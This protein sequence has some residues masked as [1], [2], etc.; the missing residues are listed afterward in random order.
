MKSEELRVAELAVFKGLK[1][2]EYFVL[3]AFLF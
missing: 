1:L 3:L 2:F